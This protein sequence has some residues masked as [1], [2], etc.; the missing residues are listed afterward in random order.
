[1]PALGGVI[2]AA[3][4]PLDEALAPDIAASVAH[5]RRLLSAGCDGINLLGTTGEA[6]SLSVE[7]RLGVMAA[8][9][10]SG[11]PLDRFMAGTGAASLADAVRLTRAAAL[12]GFAGALVLPPF[13][14]KSVTLDGVVA[15]YREVIER[16]DDDRLRLYFYH[17]PQLSG[18]FIEPEA[19]GRVAAAYP[20]IVAGVK[21]SSGDLQYS[22]D[23]VRSF[24]NLSIFPSSESVLSAARSQGFAGCISASVNVTAPLARD[25]WNGLG[26]ERA[27]IN[28]TALR[29][30][31]A[32]F[33]LIP[34][35]RQLMRAIDGDDG[36]LRMLPP[37]HRLS[38]DEAQTLESALAAQPAFASV[39]TRMKAQRG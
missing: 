22:V 38:A 12:L 31:I 37:L 10:N 24:P 34:A 6:T 28:L 4:T 32:R 35:L 27:R 16:V 7:Q 13:Y 8:I 18:V 26:G 39:A 5:C 20:S 1:M 19:I 17:F 11:L 23:L 3:L 9:A 29:E 2:C 33:A 36:W 14:Y 30:T 21:D 25:V 15:F